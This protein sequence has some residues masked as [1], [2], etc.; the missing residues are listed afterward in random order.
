MIRYRIFKSKGFQGARTAAFATNSKLLAEVYFNHQCLVR[1]LFTL[2]VT[3][4]DPPQSSTNS[5]AKTNLHS[6]PRF[7]PFAVD[8]PDNFGTFVS[9]PLRLGF[10]LLVTQLGQKCVHKS[11][12]GVRVAPCNKV[13]VYARVYKHFPYW[14]KD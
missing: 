2:K 8:E 4:S 1:T 13:A 9:S 5:S 7:V 10:F 11:L 6:S 3:T 14:I 12:D